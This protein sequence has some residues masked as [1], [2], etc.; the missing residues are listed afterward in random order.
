[1]SPVASGVATAAP[2]S[3]RTGTCLAVPPL[4]AISGVNPWRCSIASRYFIVRGETPLTIIG[5]ISGRAHATFGVVGCS[6]PM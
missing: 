5:V 6:C 1:M 4:G 2:G 3:K